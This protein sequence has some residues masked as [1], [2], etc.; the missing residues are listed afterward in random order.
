[1]PVTSEGDQAVSAVDESGNIAS[2]SYFTEFGID[3]IRQENAN[4]QARLDAI[5]EALQP[6]ASP[7]AVPAP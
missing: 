7:A 4:L 3:S 6:A 2:T 5:L 1:M